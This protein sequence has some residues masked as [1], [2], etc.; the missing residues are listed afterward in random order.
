MWRKYVMARVTSRLIRVRISEALQPL[1]CKRGFTLSAGDDLSHMIGTE[2][3][4]HRKLLHGMI[5]KAISRERAGIRLMSRY[6]NALQYATLRRQALDQRIANRPRKPRCKPLIA[7]ACTGRE[8]GVRWVICSAALMLML[9]L[10]ACDRDMRRTS[11]AA[12][13]KA[14][15]HV[16]V[17]VKIS[18]ISSPEGTDDNLSG[19]HINAAALQLRIEAPGIPEHTIQ[20]P[21]TTADNVVSVPAG[22][23]RMFHLEVENHW[24][25]AIYQ[26]WPQISDL[27]AGEDL[28]LWFHLKPIETILPLINTSAYPG[29]ETVLIVDE[30]DSPLHGLRLTL[31]DNAITQPLNVSIDEVYH[32]NGLSA[33]E[34][35]ASVLID[36]QPH[37]VRLSSP[38]TLTFPY[39][40][41]LLKRLQLTESHLRIIGTDLRSLRL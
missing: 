25:L 27:V 32:A 9:G 4:H 22:A 29:R 8:Q 30:E 13:V 5:A 24:G 14:K 40:Q 28:E 12:L 10:A 36:I 2:I 31:P 16:N 37:D 6:A 18:G 20:L 39:Y 23:H 38:A 35:Q 3:A 41:A 21:V 33:P 15:H 1:N 19:F 11:A 34:Q 7:F 17:A 26:S